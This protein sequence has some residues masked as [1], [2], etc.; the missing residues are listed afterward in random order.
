MPIFG[1]SK[2]PA[3]KFWKWFVKNESR[4]LSMA[5][6]PLVLEAGDRVRKGFPGV[7]LE[8][9]PETQRP[10]ELLISA[11][12]LR[13]NV[14]KVEEIA[15][16]APALANWTITRF[17]RAHEGYGESELQFGP[18]S[19]GKETVRA[20]L[21]RMED[22]RPDVDLYLEGYNPDSEQAQV[23]HGAAFILLDMAIGEYNVICLVGEIRFHPLADAPDDSIAWGDFAT[24]FNEMIG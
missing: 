15:D 11:D 20:K 2:A 3:E 21:T 13:E 12:G 14:S 6:E 4:L 22:G 10:R 18:V 7:M 19:L 23:Y 16:A 5:G 8:V 1:S 9:G 24:R 17:R